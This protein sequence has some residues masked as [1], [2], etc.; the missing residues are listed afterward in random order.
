MRQP[1]SVGII[2]AIVSGLL[3]GSRCVP[4]HTRCKCTL[5]GSSFVLKKKG[6]L[7]SGGVTDGGVGYLKSVC[8]SLGV[9]RS[10]ADTPVGLMVDRY[11]I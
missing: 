11:T 10:E 8:Y 3:I 4:L 7:R 6:L 1:Y 5:T 2:L 9:V